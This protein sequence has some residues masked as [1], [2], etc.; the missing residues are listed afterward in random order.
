MADFK[1]F[2]YSILIK[3]HHLDTFGHVNN[4]TYLVLLEEARWEFLYAYGIDLKTIQ[5][6]GTGPI[7]LECHIRFLREIT[8]RQ[9]ILIESR[10]LSWENK[11]GVMQQTIRNEQGE[12]CAAA[13]VT[14]GIFDMNTRKLILPPAEWLVATGMD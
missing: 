8:L 14:F 9:L 4:A 12:T 6:S 7:I 2:K 13:Q 10:M 5:T 3:E 11:I 1:I